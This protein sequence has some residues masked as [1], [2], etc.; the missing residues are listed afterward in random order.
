LEKSG[1]R[2]AR[3]GAQPGN[4]I[5]APYCEEL[6]AAI[7]RRRTSRDPQA[8][9]SFIDFGLA[10]LSSFDIALP[11]CP[12]SNLTDLALMFGCEDVRIEVGN[13]LLT[14]LGDAQ[15]AQ[16]FTDVRI[17]GLPEELGIVGA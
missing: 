6:A 15:I 10:A 8:S 17:H 13:P 14:L 5:A 2:S 9:E 4:V 3:S 16:G 7:G 11:T 1:R 12:E